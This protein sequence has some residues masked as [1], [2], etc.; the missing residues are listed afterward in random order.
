[1]AINRFSKQ[2]TFA[3]FTPES[4]EKMSVVPSFYGKLYQERESLKGVLSNLNMTPAPMDLERSQQIASDWDKALKEDTEQ[5]MRTGFTDPGVSQRMTDLVSRYTN[6]QKNDIAGIN[7]RRSQYDDEM[8]KFDDLLS[9]ADEPGERTWIEKQ[10]ADYQQSAST[11]PFKNEEGSV[12]GLP[13]AQYVDHR[14][15]LQEIMDLMEEAD[16]LNSLMSAGQ[17]G[18]SLSD[19]IG[20]NA[21]N[22]TYAYGD[23]KARL[24]EAGFSIANSYVQ[25]PEVRNYFM[26]MNELYGNAS[27]IELVTDKETGE[28]RIANT[29]MLTD[30]NGKFLGF[31]TNTA[32]GSSLDAAIKA[33]FGVSYDLNIKGGSTSAAGLGIGGSLVDMSAMPKGMVTSVTEGG[34]SNVNTYQLIQNN[35]AEANNVLSTIDAEVDQATN[36]IFDKLSGVGVNLPP[37]ENVRGQRIMLQEVSNALDQKFETANQQQIAVRRA[38]TKYVGTE[39]EADVLA[40]KLIGDPTFME[41]RKMLKGFHDTKIRRDQLNGVIE[42]KVAQYNAAWQTKEL[43]SSDLAVYNQGNPTVL[44][45]SDAQGIWG[46]V[47]DTYI[48]RMRQSVEAAIADHGDPKK[49]TTPRSRASGV[50]K[51]G[52]RISEQEIEKD[53]QILEQFLK[54]SLMAADYSEGK[55]SPIAQLKEVNQRLSVLNIDAPETILGK[56]FRPTVGRA[57]ED[58]LYPFAMEFGELFTQG[59]E[60][61]LGRGTLENFRGYL[62]EV[63][64]GFA[65][66]SS[67]GM[68]NDLTRA[69]NQLQGMVSRNTDVADMVTDQA[70]IQKLTITMQDAPGSNEFKD[71]WN[72]FT[73]DAMTHFSSSGAQYLKTS[74]G[75]NLDVVLR[76]DPNLANIDPDEPI[77][78]TPSTK[79]DLGSFTDP[80]TGSQI[81]SL[82]LSGDVEYYNDKEDKRVK[83]PMSP[84]HVSLEVFPNLEQYRESLDALLWMTSNNQ[85]GNPEQ[86]MLASTM[87]QTVGQDLIQ[88]SGV[89]RDAFERVPQKQTEMDIQLKTGEGLLGLTALDPIKLKTF[90]TS[91]GVWE[92]RLMAGGAFGVVGESPSAKLAAVEEL[93]GEHLYNQI[94]L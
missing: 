50:I 74:S 22:L 90:Q 10:R 36:V 51:E 60:A 56:V 17:M 15:H 8:K 12:Q 46:G 70:S 48:G 43:V 53:F 49:G 83:G 30:E 57:V 75:Q 39:F 73:E 62:R 11:T 13:S 72:G 7:Y 21:Q 63:D 88:N 61:L 35:L 45:F 26:K 23:R 54:S 37:A 47:V 20:G 66:V 16:V 42:Q 25:D 32:L 9:K 94:F 79:L 55:P 24:L 78:F 82:I 76:E 64:A 33:K 31:D 3:K 80:I 67:A 38:L 85:K 84:V 6:L 27:G 92:W 4:L 65:Q 58:I 93:I 19:L 71:F 14:D 2:R 29:F 91:N 18:T 87:N 81:P 40:R 89:L 59:G 86:A 68:Y 77:T 52:A 34:V 69:M 41:Y 5:F 1:M 28:S 44:S